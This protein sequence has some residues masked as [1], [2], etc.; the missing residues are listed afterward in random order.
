MKKKDII[1]PK[2]YLDVV[3]NDGYLHL[4]F[5]S[6]KFDINGTRRIEKETIEDDSK[7]NKKTHLIDLNISQFNFLKKYIEIQKRVLVKHEKDRNYDSI[8]VVN[9]SLNA[10]IGFKQD[11]EKWFRENK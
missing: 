9:Y 2:L 10:M 8:R 7:I 5:I 11:F 4:N 6:N 3:C 1:H